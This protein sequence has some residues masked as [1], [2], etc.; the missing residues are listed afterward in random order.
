MLSFFPFI[1]AEYDKREK[2]FLKEKQN[3][4]FR[5]GDYDVA[6]DIY[7]P[8]LDAVDYKIIWDEV[9]VS[10]P[11]DDLG[12]QNGFVGVLSES[13]ARN[14]FIDPIHYKYI[15]L[16]LDEQSMPDLAELIANT[17]KEGRTTPEEIWVVLS[18]WDS[19]GSGGGWDL[20]SK[21][22]VLKVYAPLKRRYPFSFHLPV[23]KIV[24]NR[25]YCSSSRISERNELHDAFNSP[26]PSFYI[27]DTGKPFIVIF[28]LKQDF[29]DKR[30]N[31]SI[32]WSHGYNVD[33]FSFNINNI[34]LSSSLTITISILTVIA[35]SLVICVYFS[36]KQLL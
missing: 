22:L 30:F 10:T 17:I 26:I 35:L 33:T 14:Q 11:S 6:I 3:N 15:T 25:S 16:S 9:Y 19:D 7:M 28:K 34:I 1:Q 2:N 23:K 8:G 12:I 13:N 29:K 4:E 27:R 32:V 31:G 5:P 20:V 21:S 18:Y 24:T 36:Y